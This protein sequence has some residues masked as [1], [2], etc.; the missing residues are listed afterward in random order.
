MIDI[1]ANAT[2]AAKKKET[3]GSGADATQAPIGKT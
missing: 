1:A 3:T 2:S